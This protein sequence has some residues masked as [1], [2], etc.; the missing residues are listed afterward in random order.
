MDLVDLVGDTVSVAERKGSL[1]PTFQ[2]CV[3]LRFFHAEASIWLSVICL[4]AGEVSNAADYIG[5]QS[6]EQTHLVKI[7]DNNFHRVAAVQDDCCFNSLFNDTLGEFPGVH[8]LTID[9]EVC[10]K[11]MARWR[12]PIA[13]RLD[14]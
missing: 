13:I 2:F 4:A 3:A 9:P 14:L 12:I 11:S 8:H 6:N 7:Q 1:T 10:P 5:L